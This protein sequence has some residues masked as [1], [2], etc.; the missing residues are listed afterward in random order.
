MMKTISYQIIE[1]IHLIRYN[2]LKIIQNFIKEIK[3]YV[4]IL[5]GD[6]TICERR[7]NI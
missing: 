7:R 3:F 1:D 4:E 2:N 5:Y 6:I